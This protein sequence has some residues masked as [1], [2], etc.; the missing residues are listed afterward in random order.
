MCL[1]LMSIDVFFLLYH[2][3]F[4]KKGPGVLVFTLETLLYNRMRVTKTF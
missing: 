4:A 1:P 3:V 2:S